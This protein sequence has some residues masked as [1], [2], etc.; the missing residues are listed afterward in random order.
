MK[1][2]FTL[3]LTLATPL[4]A[5]HHGE[6]KA[7]EKTNVI[8][9]FLDDCGYNDLSCYGSKK[10]KTPHLDRMAAEGARFTN[11]LTA[12]SVC[13]PSRSAL[14]TGKYPIRLGLQRGV[15]FPQ[16]KAGLNP[17]EYTIAEHFKSA[18]YATACVGKWHLGH[19]PEVLPRAHGFDSYYGI[20]YSNDM[21][22]PANKGKP[23]PAS[24]ESWTTQKETWQNWK[25]PLIQNE[26][27]IELPV[28]QRTIT[29]R[30]TDQAI[31]FVQANKEK[32]FFL[33]LPHSMPHIPLYVP[34]DALDPDPANAYTCT[35]Q[36][37]DAEIGRLLETLRTEKLADNTLVI[38]TTDNGP[39]LQFKNHGGNADPLREGKG[40]PYEGGHRVPF[41][42][43]APGKIKPG[44]TSSEILTALDL[45]PTLAPLSGKNL[46]DGHKI[47]G[48][49]LTD[50]LLNNGQ[51]T[52]KEFIYYPAWK[53]G[54]AAIRIVQEN[55]DWKYFPPGK[56]TRK[57]KPQPAQLFNLALDIGEKN[58][59]ADKHPDKAKA[60]QALLEK[61]HTELQQGNKPKWTTDKKH[62]WPDT[63]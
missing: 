52:R 30:Y 11:F 47:D 42:A 13:T 35:I 32:P 61:R 15:L 51:S 39:W 33:Y 17:E 27:I 20:P 2:I 24:D 22:H 36:H 57:K 37:I 10:I 41:I 29:R 45:L 62:P 56:V 53:D 50:A 16:S 12:S 59:L 43:W 54:P 7:A 48:L 8:I 60:L 26:K 23:K 25:T 14:L 28:N 18:G 63:L 38:F 40:T 58:N 5:D 19:Y 1:F 31:K 46:P 6:K 4:L 49:N 3:I 21:N 9:I 44:T 55:G 34:D